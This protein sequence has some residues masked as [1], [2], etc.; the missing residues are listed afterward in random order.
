MHKPSNAQQGSIIVSILISSIFLFTVVT[1]LIVL[2]NSNLTRAKNRILFLQSQYAAE[3]GADAAIAYLNADPAAAYVGSGA[4]EI[5]ILSNAQY[6]STF[7]TTVSAGK[8]SNERII[9]STGRVYRPQ[10]ALTA[11]FAYKIEVTT[12]R[13]VGE[14]SASGILSRNIIE[15]ASNVKNI[16]ARDIFVNGYIN[17]NK[18]STNLIAENITVGGKNTSASNCSIG[19]SGSLIKPTTFTTAGQTKTKI[20]MAFNNCINPPG[21]LSNA[22]FDVLA[23]QTNIPKIQSTYIPWSQFMDGTYTNSFSACSDWTGGTFPRSIPSAGHL[24]QTHYP[25][26]AS[27]VSAACGVSGDLSLATGQYNIVDNVHLR[28]NL[29]AATACTPTFYNPSSSTRYIFVEGNVNFNGVNTAAGS[30]PIVLI[31]Y[32]VDPASKSSVCPIGGSMYI[33]GS[34]AA[35]KLYFLASNGLCF[36]KTKFTA[37]PSFGGISGKN[38]YIDTN[39]GNPFDP[40]LDVTFP[41]SSV[42]VDLAWHSARYRRL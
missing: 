6:R 10:S 14:I 12:Q 7:Q 1:G 33:G 5:S 24:K 27:G 37:D 8:T 42:P 31:S 38:I 35:P 21:N 4:T 28:A 34:V 25:D 18:P 11:N 17:M 39:A 19:G 23:N 26:N 29:C 30:G 2:A 22:D 9:T 13:T 3:S 32:G 20:T 36:E 40:S 41:L 16:K 15:I